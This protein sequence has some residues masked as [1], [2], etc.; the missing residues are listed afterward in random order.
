MTDE[1]MEIENGRY[2][3][4]AFFVLPLSSGNIAVLHPNRSLYC[5]CPDWESAKD[6]G[7]NAER[8]QLR[9][10][11]RP[12]VDTLLKNFDM[13]SIDLISLDIAGLL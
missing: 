1:E 13:S 4:R 8:D 9:K 11:A 7:P 3:H 10:I 6:N 5:V 2:T 12:P